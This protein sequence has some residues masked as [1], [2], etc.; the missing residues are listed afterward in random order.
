MAVNISSLNPDRSAA[1]FNAG[2]LMKITCAPWI[3]RRFPKVLVFDFDQMAAS[4]VSAGTFIEKLRHETV[5]K[6]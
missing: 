3:A 5:M 6:F 4:F 2:P 1:R